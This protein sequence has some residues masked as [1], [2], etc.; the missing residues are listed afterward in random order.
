[1]DAPSVGSTDSPVMSTPVNK[2]RQ[3]QLNKGPGRI[4]TGYQIFSSQIWL[5]VKSEMASG[6]FA[7]ISREIGNQWR[8]LSE[9]D[10]QHYEE[11]AKK[12]NEEN[13]LKAAEER[14]LDEHPPP[15]KTITIVHPPPAAAAG[16]S[17]STSQN[18]APVKQI[19]PIF[20]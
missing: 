10:K 20:H 6:N 18:A 16:P 11:K 14:K 17:V 7:E 12:M 2:K 19:E 9:T 3:A 5:R 1:M 15:S 13:A 8:S 4:R